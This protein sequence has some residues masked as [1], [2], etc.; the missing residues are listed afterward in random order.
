VSGEIDRSRRVE[1]SVDVYRLR[2]AALAGGA[3]VLAWDYPGSTLL[4]VR[5]LRVAAAPHAG[6]PEPEPGSSSAW[7][8][9]YDGDTGSFRDGGLPTGS[10]W[11][12]AVFARDGDGP[13]TLWRDEVVTLP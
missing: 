10:A 4:R 2:L 5:I 13:W 12:Y 11:R 8:L 1:T 6:L 7:Q 3:V 9:V